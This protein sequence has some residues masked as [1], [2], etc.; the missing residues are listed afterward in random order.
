MGEETGSTFLWGLKVGRGQDGVLHEGDK[1][2]H[3]SNSKT[4]L[5]SRD[6]MYKMIN[7]IN[8][9]VGYM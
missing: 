8:I 3:T 7:I 6:V 1:K 9:S 2:V 4:K 5:S